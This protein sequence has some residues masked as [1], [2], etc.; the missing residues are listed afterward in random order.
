[1]NA[2]KLF[3]IT[4]FIGA[5]VFALALVVILLAVVGVET[6]GRRVDLAIPIISGFVLMMGSK[7][8]AGAALRK[9]E[10]S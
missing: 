1:M 6:V 10:K 4:Y 9:A 8:A 7:F 2:V 3:T 5:A